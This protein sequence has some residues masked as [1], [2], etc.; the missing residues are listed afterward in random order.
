MSSWVVLRFKN[1]EDQTNIVPS[2]WVDK[3]DANFQVLWAWYPPYEHSDNI[4]AVKEQDMPEAEWLFL[5]VDQIITEAS[6]GIF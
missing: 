3:D 2:S 6:K 1:Y 5:E 4:E